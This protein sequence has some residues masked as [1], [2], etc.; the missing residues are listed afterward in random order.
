MWLSRN[1]KV[2]DSFSPQKWGNLISDQ[3]TQCPGSLTFSLIS[4][5][6]INDIPPIQGKRIMDC[7][8]SHGSIT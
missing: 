4:V 8:Q 3:V 7:T 2:L 5:T 1:T 6:S